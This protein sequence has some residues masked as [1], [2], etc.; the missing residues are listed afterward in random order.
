MIDSHGCWQSKHLHAPQGLNAS[1]IAR[2]LALDPRTVASWLA[3]DHFRPRT[4]PPHASTRD[5]FKAPIAH[6]LERS[7]ASAAQVFQRLR[8][9][10]FDGGYSIVKAY[11]RT[12]R[13]RRQ[14]AFLTLAFAPGECAQVDWGAFGSVPVGQTSRRLRCFGIV[15]CDSRLRDVECTGSQ[16]MEHCLACHQHALACLGGIPKTILLDTLTSAVLQ[17]VLGEAPV[18]KP[19]YRACATPHGVTSAPCHVG[20]GH[21]KGRV[22][23]GVGSVTQHCL[24]GL[25]IP[26]CSA[27]TPAARQW[28]RYGG[29]GAPA[30]RTPGAAGPGLAHRAAA[31]QP[32]AAA[33]VRYRHGVPGACLPAVAHD[34]RHQP[35]LRPHPLCRSGAHTQHL[36]R[37]PVS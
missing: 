13:P 32:P 20:K 1:P 25:E 5:P 36:S 11:V 26:D 15:R 2:A 8:E 10:G 6:R 12:V 24:A 3:Q 9:Q 21:A 31:P 35:R 17:R 18:F 34:P 22:D 23:N 27:L 14:P 7:P 37:S 30:Q 29:Q 33:A 4:P 28:A 19:T 16:T